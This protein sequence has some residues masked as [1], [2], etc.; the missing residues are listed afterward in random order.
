MFKLN[1]TIA[2]GNI[3]AWIYLMEILEESEKIITY[4]ENGELVGFCGYAKWN[5]K[6][7]LLRKKLANQE[8]NIKRVL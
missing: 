6:K 3:C 2:E 1:Y 4:K 8:S 7:Y 5:S